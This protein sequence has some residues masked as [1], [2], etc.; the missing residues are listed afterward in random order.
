MD[1]TK[2]DVLQHSP[3]SDREL[4]PHR[5]GLRKKM[6]TVSVPPS[7][8]PP[9]TEA[10][11]AIAEF[12]KAMT[13]TPKSSSNHPQPDSP[14]SS[15]GNLLPEDNYNPATAILPLHSSSVTSGDEAA[16]LHRSNMFDSSNEELKNVMQSE[17][18]DVQSSPVF[19]VHQNKDN[20][21]EK[22]RI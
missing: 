12:Q 1:L 11:L 19:G 21:S 16:M 3:N 2:L 14:M 17:P 10:D 5:L 22:V 7:T 18:S 13:S 20:T 4:R 15:H 8:P 9:P 6:S